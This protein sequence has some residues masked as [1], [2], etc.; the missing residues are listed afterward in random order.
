MYKKVAGNYSIRVADFGLAC[1]KPKAQKS[2][3][4]TAKGTPLTRAPE[5]RCN[6]KIN[7]CLTINLDHG[8][9]AF[10]SEG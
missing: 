1:I 8:R 6:F 5:V 7:E 3:R 2:L 4:D 10:Q 9:Q